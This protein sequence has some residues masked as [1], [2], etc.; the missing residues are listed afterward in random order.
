MGVPLSGSS[1]GSAYRSRKLRE[2][3][4]RIPWDTFARFLACVHEE[5]GWERLDALGRGLAGAPSW[6]FP[7][8][9]ASWVVSPR[10]FFVGALS[11]D[12]PAVFPAVGSHISELPDGTATWSSGLRRT[13]FRH[14][15]FFRISRTHLGHV[16]TLLALPEAHVEAELSDRGGVY[17]IT[18]PASRT[19]ASKLRRR[20]A[21]LL[22]APAAVRA[23]EEEQRGVLEAAMRC[24]GRGGSST[25]SSRPCPSASACT[26]TGRSS[27]PTP[28]SRA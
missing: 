16:A 13:A 21:T 1:R 7:R 18:L 17:L 2:P 24:P 28:P 20:A 8:R 26:G 10:R 12:R 11:F 19:L 25:V 6:E 3:G 9:F 5:V 15:E 23:L 22:H 14:P 27:T 4:G